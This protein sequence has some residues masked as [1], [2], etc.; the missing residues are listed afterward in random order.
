MIVGSLLCVIC[1]LVGNVFPP[2]VIEVGLITYNMIV[3]V[4]AAAWVTYVIFELLKNYHV[5]K[6]LPKRLQ[7]CLD[8][9]CCCCSSSGRRKSISFTADHLQLRPKS[10]KQLK[11]R[12]TNPRYAR[13]A[14]KQKKKR[15]QSSMMNPSI[16]VENN[17]ELPAT[18][19]PEEGENS[20]GEPGQ[21]RS[22]CMHTPGEEETKNTSIDS[23]D[24]TTGIDA[25]VFPV[26]CT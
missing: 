6:H 21:A 19:K 17:I 7:R 4:A 15:R 14:K 26:V 16:L 5:Y 13:H 3:F 9:F 18:W 8:L 20:R 22:I 1:L 24:A 25:S 10:A 2:L 11:A 23:D 12:A